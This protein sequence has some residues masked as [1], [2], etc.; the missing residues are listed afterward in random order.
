MWGKKKNCRLYFKWLNHIGSENFVGEIRSNRTGDHREII[1]TRYS[2]A[3]MQDAKRPRTSDVEIPLHTGW[4]G[5]RE[6]GSP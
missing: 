6:G 1:D 3:A 2:I 5:G 4:E